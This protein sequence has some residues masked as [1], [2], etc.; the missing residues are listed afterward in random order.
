MKQ[1]IKEIA[2][3]TYEKILLFFG[4]L[5]LLFVLISGNISNFFKISGI[6]F[7]ILLVMFS[8]LLKSPLFDRWKAPKDGMQ[9]EF[10]SF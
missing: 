6:I 3:L 5:G 7:F 10:D 9:P 1:I 8:I 2:K 4:V